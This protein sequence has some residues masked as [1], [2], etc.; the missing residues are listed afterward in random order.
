LLN[1]LPIWPLDG[2]Q[3]AREL[4]DFFSPGRGIR[5]ALG[6]SMLIAGGI[7]V[8]ALL[9]MNGMKPLSPY[10]PASGWFTI[11]M[12]GMLAVWNY[13]EMQQLSSS[14]PWGSE[15]APWDRDADAWRR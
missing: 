6:L 4:F 2:G 14:N 12:F 11:M 3:I 13:Q 10:L 8:H 9:V 5:T 15:G 1:L 7:A